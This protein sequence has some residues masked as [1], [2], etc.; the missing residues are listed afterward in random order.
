MIASLITV[1]SRVIDRPAS[2]AHDRHAAAD[3]RFRRGGSCQALGAAVVVPAGVTSWMTSNPSNSGC[4][5][6]S[7]RPSRASR[8]AAR[9]ASERVPGLE[10]GV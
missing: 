5:N 2:A 6:V 10:I 9:N 3:R 8:C 4:D 7:D 1:P